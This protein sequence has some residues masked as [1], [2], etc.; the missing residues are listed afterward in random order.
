[1]Y[2]EIGDLIQDQLLGK[3]AFGNVYL[4]KH[5]YS[6]KS[7]A[8]KI[9][10]KLKEEYK[11]TSQYLQSEIKILTKLNNHPNII[12]LEQKLENKNHL[13]LVMEYCNGGTLSDCLRKYININNT[14]GFTEEIIQRIMRQIVNALYYI[15]SNNIIHRDLKLQNIMVNFDNEKDRV[16]LNM[17]KANVK[18]IDF[19]LSKELSNNSYTNSVL[20]TLNYMAPKLVEEHYRLRQKEK[21]EKTIGYGKEIDIWAL[22]CICYELLRGRQVFESNYE[23]DLIE[24]MKDGN[25]QLPA[26]CSYEYISFLTSMLQ[27]EGKDRITAKGLLQKSFIVNDAKYFTSYKDETKKKQRADKL[28]ELNRSLASFQAKFNQN[29]Y[30]KCKTFD[31]PRPIPEESINCSNSINIQKIPIN[32]SY[33]NTEGPRYIYGQLMVDNS[34]N[35]PPYL[36]SISQPINRISYLPIN[37]NPMS[38]NKSIGPNYNRTKSSNQIQNNNSNPC[39]NR[40]S[41]IIMRQ[42]SDNINMNNQPFA[43]YYSGPIPRK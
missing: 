38:L 27:Y 21:I 16:N 15:H 4:Y 3:G 28:F 42:N 12:K 2:R 35:N 6:N 39:N 18:I 43:H 41:S 30:K 32:Q 9:I 36:K 17:M 37:P 11:G 25:Y 31:D 34:Q 22:G 24:Q 40:L 8:V 7:Y 1:M 14:K 10:D 20:G 26:T 29:N 23:S 5:K 19:G 13:L 33:N